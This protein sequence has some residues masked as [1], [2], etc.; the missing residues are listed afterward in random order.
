VKESSDSSD[1]ISQLLDKDE[2]EAAPQSLEATTPTTSINRKRERSVES[3]YSLS[4]LSV[5]KKL[6]EAKTKIKVPKVS[7]PIKKV[8]L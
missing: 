7:F 6:Q 2:G 5:I 1:N 3:K 8:G 4:N